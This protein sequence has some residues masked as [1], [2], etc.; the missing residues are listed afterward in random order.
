MSADTIRALKSISDRLV[1]IDPSLFQ[2]IIDNLPDGLLIADA[3]GHIILVNRQLEL[4]FGYSRSQLLDKPVETL[5]PE[6]KREA[7][8][9]Y[10]AD[11]FRAPAARPM[12]KAMP[13]TGLRHDGSLVTVQIEL[14]PLISSQGVWGLAL[15]RRVGDGKA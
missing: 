10:F 6:D 8:K 15:I 5:I 11:Y 12:N 2:Q 14:G 9:K 1:D 4:M 3:Q 7:H 13:L